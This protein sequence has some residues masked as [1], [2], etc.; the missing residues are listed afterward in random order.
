MTAFG[1][2]LDS[3]RSSAYLLHTYHSALLLSPCTSI[4][5]KL[6][7]PHT[8][9]F[10]RVIQ[11]LPVSWDPIT[12]TTGQHALAVVAATWSPCSRF[13]AVTWFPSGMVEVLDAVTLKQLHTFKSLPDLDQWLIFSPDGHLLTKFSSKQG[14]TSWDL[15][16]GGKISTIPVELYTSPGKCLSSTYSMDGKLVTVAYEDSVNTTPTTISTYNILSGSH[17]YSHHVSDG[18]VV[19]P[20][21]TYGNCLRFVIIKSGL[22][23]IWEAELNSMHML[24]EVESLPAPDSIDCSEETLFLP[25][26]SWLAFTLEETIMVWDAQNSKFLLNFPGVDEP[27]GMSFSP[28]GCFFTCGSGNWEVYLWKESPTGYILHQKLTLANYRTTTPLLS[29]SGELVVVLNA[30]KV[31]LYHTTDPITFFSSVPTRFFKMENFILGFSPDETWVVVARLQEKMA[32]VLDLRSG[33]TW[34]TIST[35]MEILGLQATRNTIAIA[36]K[37]NIVTW[38]LPAGHSALNTRVDINDCVQTTMFD[39]PLQEHDMSGPYVSIPPGFNYIA[40]AHG[41]EGVEL[42]SVSTGKFLAC[43]TTVGWS[44]PWFTPDEKEVWF[45]NSFSDE[46]WT[47]IEDSKSGLT[48]LEPL[49]PTAHPSVGPS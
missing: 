12:A 43:T 9:P 44:I 41:S 14:L 8:H 13:I 39:P 45:A 20:I 34:L 24:S 42:Y 16:T 47:I 33:D 48:R 36:S 11:G 17:I 26:L 37:G 30:S 4:V 32:R 3:L 21:W 1:L 35:D 10:V 46:G 7:K 28:D 25:K 2:S 27:S 19:A 23:T 5:H 6:Y 22:I 18:H 15:Q 40:V 49:G 38:N 31:H 29:P